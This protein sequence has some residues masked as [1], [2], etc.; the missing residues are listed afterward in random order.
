MLFKKRLEEYYKKQLLLKGQT[1]SVLVDEM[2][3]YIDR[4]QVEIADYRIYLQNELNNVLFGLQKR[5]NYEQKFYEELE[6]KLLIYSQLYFN[7][8]LAYKRRESVIQNKKLF[9]GKME[10]INN[11]QKLYDEY[12]I[13]CDALIE[14]LSGES[15]MKS[16]LKLISIQNPDLALVNEES[17]SKQ[18]EKVL[19]YLSKENQYL[20]EVRFFFQDIWKEKSSWQKELNTLKVHRYQ[21]LKQKKACKEARTKLLDW[22]QSLKGELE[23]IK[24]C[25]EEISIKEKESKSEIIELWK[26][27]IKESGEYISYQGQIDDFYYQKGKINNHK[28]KLHEEKEK[29]KQC[30]ADYRRDKDGEK[31]ECERLYSKMKQYEQNIWFLISDNK[32]LKAKKADYIDRVRTFRVQLDDYYSMKNSKWETVNYYKDRH[33][34]VPN[35]DSIM[36]D[37]NLYTRKIIEWKGYIDS[38]QREINELK[39]RIAKNQDEIDALNILKEQIYSERNQRKSRIEEINILINQNKKR[40]EDINKMIDEDKEKIRLL[41]M[42][43][44]EQNEYKKD[45][46]DNQLKI[47]RELLLQCEKLLA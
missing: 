1:V 44:Q 36:Y 8:N 45:F 39:E 31:A 5:Y 33:E 15:D 20:L 42:Y 38:Y 3:N 14:I 10:L 19:G 12:V 30:I 2:E 4:K 13:E 29:I 18:Y 28:N 25:L 35:F 9:H 24:K 46:M 40:C 11:Y 21:N 17:V 26:N 7:K 23:E 37:I 34:A 32:R 16:Y 47:I 41:N 27:H 6:E 43:I 22:N